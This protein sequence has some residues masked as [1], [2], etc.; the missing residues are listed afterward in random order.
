[1]KIV[2]IKN[3]PIKLDIYDSNLVTVAFNFNAGSYNEN[4]DILGIAHLVE[5]LVFR[6]TTNRNSTEINEYIES[7]GGYLNAYTS[8]ENTKF[9]CTVPSEYVKEAIELLYDIT[10]NNTVPVDEFELEKDIVINELK[11]Y[12]DDPQSVCQENLF[13]LMFHNAI[14]RQ[15]VGGTP[16]TVSKITREQVLNYIKQNFTLDNLCIIIT[17]KVKEDILLYINS[18]LVDKKNSIKINNNFNFNISN[19]LIKTSKDGIQQ[20]Q[21]MWGIVGPSREH[22]DSIPFALI[23]TY[24]GGNASSVLYKEIR[25]KRGYVYTISTYIEWLNDYSVL[26]GYASLNEANIKKTMQV[27]YDAYK[28]LNN[29]NLEACKNYV[30]GDLYRQVETTSGNNDNYTYYNTSIEDRV[31]KVKAVTIQDIQKVF[32]KYFNQKIVF[33]I[34]TPKEVNII[35]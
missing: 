11:M 31:N 28:S 34:V 2:K 24:L 30:I 3:V 18:I 12:E 27:I 17:G 25:E 4:K 29:I 1:M 16:K 5:H 23:M 20:S 32:K 9:Y 35:E 26:I 33:S 21:L 8:Q 6:G 14:N 19:T 22:I 13:K 10:F 15:V 7:L